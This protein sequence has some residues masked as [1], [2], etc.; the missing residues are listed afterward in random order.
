M[1]QNIDAQGTAIRAVPGAVTRS[2][3]ATTGGGS[4]QS[5]PIKL[6]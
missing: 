2:P 3:E 5:T 1:H 6:R 4:P